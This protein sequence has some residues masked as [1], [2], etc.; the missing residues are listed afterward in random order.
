MESAMRCGVIFDLDGTLVDTNYLHALAW[1]R[2]FREAGRYV[3]MWSIHRV[4]GMS[5]DHLLKELIG[6]GD[7]AISDGHGR[8]FRGFL[9]EMKALPGAGELLAEVHRRGACVAVATSAKEQDLEAMLGVGGA[10][11]P[12][13]DCVVPAA[14]VERSKPA[15]DI[16]VAALERTGLRAEDAVAVGDTC[17]DVMAAQRCGV[18]CVAFRTGGIGEAELRAAGAAAV[19]DD[20]ADLLARL[21][22]SPVAPLLDGGAG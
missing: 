19:Y 13:I 21:T 3:P 11:P 18:P 17:W 2:S 4:I 6:H 8:H 7:Q 5:S 16:F 12:P 9:G 10:P 15:P 20:P 22:E 14:E 1:F